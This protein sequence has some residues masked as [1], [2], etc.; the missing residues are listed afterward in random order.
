MKPE[1]I[2]TVAVLGLGTMGHGIAQAFAAAG[3]QVRC[4]DESPPARN[5]LTDRIRSN[6]QQMGKAGI[7]TPEDIDRA[8]QSS[9]GFRLA[10]IGPLEINDFAGLDVT[11]HVYKHLVSDIRSGTQLPSGIQNLIDGGHLGVKTGR[12][13]H[14]YTPQSLGEKRALRDRRFLALARLLYN[15]A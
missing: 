2:R 12:G 9:M 10:A 5:A 13:I 15:D 1:S 3:C 14:D 8:V 11:A 6:L 7:H 4:Y